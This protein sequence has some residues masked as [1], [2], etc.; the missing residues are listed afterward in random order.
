MINTNP[1]TYVQYVTKNGFVKVKQVER[2]VDGTN[3]FYNLD[4]INEEFF[5]LGL[6]D[7]N[8]RVFGVT[9]ANI[10]NLDMIAFLNSD[11]Q[12][13]EL[14]PEISFLPP[15]QF[16]AMVVD[17]LNYDINFDVVP[18]GQSLIVSNLPQVQS[19][20]VQNLPDVQ[21]V[22]LTAA[23][24]TYK[25]PMMSYTGQFEQKSIGV[26]NQH[27][28][29]FMD[30][31]DSVLIRFQSAE[32]CTVQWQNESVHTIPYFQNYAI[33]HPVNTLLR[34]KDFLFKVVNLT[35]FDLSPYL[36]KIFFKHSTNQV[37]VFFQ[38]ENNNMSCEYNHKSIALQNG[39]EVVNAN[40]YI[41]LIVTSN[42]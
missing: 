36:V 19:V 20:N 41:K 40:N 34:C 33:P 10:Q 21:S 29:E 39:F 8:K 22:V 12:T 35:V 31:C 38:Y 25:V 7:L 17:T 26:N 32:L 6:Y 15:L 13:V 37:F 4:G 24:N 27:Y 2:D 42:G 14:L 28:H 9:F 18:A 16:V 11:F 1:H 3:V 23:P 5:I 30:G